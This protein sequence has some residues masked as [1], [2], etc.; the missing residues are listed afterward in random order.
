[1]L[2]YEGATGTNDPD[3]WRWIKDFTTREPIVL[4]FNSSVEPRYYEFPNTETF[5]E[6]YD[7]LPLIEFYIVDYTLDYL[8]AYNHSQC[9]TAIGKAA[10]WLESYDLYKQWCKKVKC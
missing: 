7:D 8:I 6:L 3:S 4:I 1:M 5:V 10:D 2:K 9:L